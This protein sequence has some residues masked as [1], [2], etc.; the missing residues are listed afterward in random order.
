MSIQEYCVDLTKI[1]ERLPYGGMIT[2]AILRNKDGSLFCVFAYDYDCGALCLPFGDGW[3]FWS[4]KQHFSENDNRNTLTVLWNPHCDRTGKLINDDG[5][6]KRTGKDA[7]A[8]FTAQIEAIRA[9]NKLRLLEKEDVLNYL[10]ACLVMESVRRAYPKLLLY[11]DV[12]LSKDLD[13][14]LSGNRVFIGKKRLQIVTIPQLA[15][16]AMNALFSD[17]QPFCYRFSRRFISFGASS[18]KKEWERYTKRWCGGRASIRSFLKAACFTS[19]RQPGYLQNSFVFFVEENEDERKEAL[20][21][22]FEKRK[23]IYCVED[24]NFK[25]AWWGTL[26]GLFRA[27]LTPPISA[28]NESGDLLL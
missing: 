15:P 22:V 3:C 12:V 27:N 4:E 17:L 20:L 26:P 9:K 13:F 10:S 21:Q 7:K 16:S 5:Q 14:R 28:L 25:D 2:D 19:A 8:Y 18:A 23:T 24:Y 1:E 11:L 6:K